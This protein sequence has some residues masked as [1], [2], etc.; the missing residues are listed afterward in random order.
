MSRAPALLGAGRVRALLARHGVTPDKSL[1][2][3]F[4]MDPNTIRK[5]VEI[6]QP[7]SE[8]R[9]LEI[10][11]GAGS[12]T[13]GLAD[14]ADSVVAVERDPRLLPVL[15]DVLEG[16]SNVEVVHADALSVDLESF[17]ASSLVANLPYNIAATVVLTVLEKVP[18]IE[19][20]TVMTQRE[21][22]ERLAA[23]PGNKVYGATS[24][25][26]AFFAEAKVA[27]SVSRNA[28]WPIP[29]V[30]SVIVRIQRRSEPTPVAAEAFF[31]VVKAAFG[32]RRKTLRNTLGAL[33]GSADAAQTLISSAGI[34]P[35]A[36]PETLG[37]EAFIE[38][39]R[40]FPASELE[41]GL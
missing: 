4:V 20:L 25:L 33:A 21:V 27:A 24:V 2:Q 16:V 11:P 30:D 22:G 5:A 1:G 29:N 10:G 37:R 7:S 35:S 18:S 15:A 17:R 23:V 8:E 3:N 6:A 12:L 28:F 40:R 9:V 41:Q 34:D 26:T 31:S 13:L 36:R 39:A 32:Q 14:A 19:T 38:L